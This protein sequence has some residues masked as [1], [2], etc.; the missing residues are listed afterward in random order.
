MDIEM[1]SL[2]LA[3]SY[4]ARGWS[5]LPIAPGRKNPMAKNWGLLRITAEDARDHFTSDYFN[6]GINLGEAS[7]QLVDV[8]IDCP[9]AEAIAPHLLPPTEAIFG[10]AAKPRSHFLYYS[11]VKTAKY[12]AID[13]KE[14]MLEIRANKCQTVFPGS[15]HET[16][17]KIEWDRQ[18]E[19]A[20]VLPSVL[21]DSV[22]RVA[23]CCLLA[24]A[25][26]TAEGSRHDLA[27][28]IA[29]GLQASGW[30]VE[31]ATLFVV[32]A[33]TA[34]GDSETEDRERAV[35]DTFESA[36]EK[37]RGWTSA[38]AILGRPVTQR[39][40]DLL[41]ASVVASIDAHFALGSSR[42]QVG[43]LVPNVVEAPL[44]TVDPS[45]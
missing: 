7:N 26:R 2:E 18:G 25:W 27:L 28:T 21:Q 12:K 43:M 30:S 42:P 9:E 11:A 8:D 14:V 41:G 13:N 40:R 39:I 10:H 4:I 45:R 5:V 37:I 29:G 38:E 34:A 15:I 3:K 35:S 33:A 1:K 23:A 44:T 20:S 6:V 17:E 36:G 16:G 31:D 19:P 22:N 32:C 24:K